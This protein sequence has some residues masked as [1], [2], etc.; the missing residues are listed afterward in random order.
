MYTQWA[1]NA[2]NKKEVGI[3]NGRRM[4]KAKAFNQ[5]F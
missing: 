3:A 5:T 4:G 2:N 1:V